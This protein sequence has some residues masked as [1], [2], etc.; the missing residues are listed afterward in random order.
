MV[1]LFDSWIK[2][3]LCTP[4]P[5]NI[6][7]QN[8]YTIWTYF[9]HIYSSMRLTFTNMHYNN[10]ICIYHSNF[11]TPRPQIPGLIGRNGPAN[12]TRGQKVL[13]ENYSPLR[14]FLSIQFSL[15]RWR[16]LFCFTTSLRRRAVIGWDGNLLG[17]P[18]LTFF[19]L[20]RSNCSGVARTGRA[21]NRMNNNSWKWLVKNTMYC[22]L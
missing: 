7:L 22:F 15:F 6:K 18:L 16:H 1:T 3:K 5:L 17:N 10:K 14:S 12:V 4:V 19:R 2:L 20:F 9:N 21:K 8:W 13:K 11:N